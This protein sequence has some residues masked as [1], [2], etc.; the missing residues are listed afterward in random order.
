[1]WICEHV[2]VPSYFVI[3]IRS[4]KTSLSLTKQVYPSDSH[5]GMGFG[6]LER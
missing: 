6:Q 4:T 5:L 1:L 3:D 2:I